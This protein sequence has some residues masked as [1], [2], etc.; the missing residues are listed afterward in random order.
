MSP[1]ASPRSPSTPVMSGTSISTPFVVPVV[2]R[3]CGDCANPTTATS[4][5]MLLRSSRERSSPGS[6]RSSLAAARCDAHSQVLPE[7]LVRRVRLTGGPEVRDVLQPE[8]PL[9]ARLPDRLDPHAH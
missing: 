3:T 5:L 2:R 1:F 9:L 4:R 6:L 8:L 7:R